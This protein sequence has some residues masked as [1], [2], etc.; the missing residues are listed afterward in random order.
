MQE[1]QVLKGNWTSFQV[2]KTF[3]HLK[4][5]QWKHDEEDTNTNIF[6][7]DSW[8]KTEVSEAVHVQLEYRGATVNRRGWQKGRQNS[9]A[10]NLIVDY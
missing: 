10:T 7:R 9:L 4:G 1:T 6:D 5:F 8:F 3:Y 2:L